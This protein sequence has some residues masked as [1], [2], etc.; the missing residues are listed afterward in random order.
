MFDA[1]REMVWAAYTKPEHMARWWGPHKYDVTV[2]EMDLRIGGKWRMINSTKDEAHEFFGE[3]L[4]IVAPEKLVW[5]FGYGDYTPAI[6]TMVFEDVNGKTRITGVSRF[7][8][9]EDR[10]GMAASG[11]E[12]GANETF[13]RLDALLK[14]L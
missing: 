14:T 9:I 5:T 12:A 1:P 2:K 7:A 11:M 13:E 10:N 4:E 6:E 3:Y 8:T